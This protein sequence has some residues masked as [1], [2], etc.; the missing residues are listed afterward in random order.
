MLPERDKAVHPV[1][2]H[3]C[4]YMHHHRRYDVGQTGEY[5]VFN[6]DIIPPF[7]VLL[8]A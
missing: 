5:L 1:K 8:S 6:Q 7:S 2:Q 4:E 3:R